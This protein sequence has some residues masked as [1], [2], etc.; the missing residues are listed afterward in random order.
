MQNIVTLA[1]EDTSV[2]LLCYGVAL[3]PQPAGMYWFVSLLQN[4]GSA[5]E[6]GHLPSA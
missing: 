3:V 5:D 4:K 6:K 2:L 1:A